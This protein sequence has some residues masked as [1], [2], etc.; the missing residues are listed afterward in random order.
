MSYRLGDDP[1]A[2]NTIDEGTLPTSPVPLILQ[3][4]G[5][6]NAG[7]LTPQQQSTLT[8]EMAAGAATGTATA[9]GGFSPLAWLGLGVV[10][11]YLVL[12]RG[13][14]RSVF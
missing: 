8:Q 9:A 4:A 3:G 5:A 14:S 12:G 7:A 1:N 11:L 6:L 2:G 13:R 10:A